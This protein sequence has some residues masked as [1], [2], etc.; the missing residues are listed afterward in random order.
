MATI[1][2]AEFAAFTIVIDERGHPATRPASFG[3]GCEDLRLALKL[4]DAIFQ[5]EHVIAAR[6]VHGQAS[7]QSLKLCQKRLSMVAHSLF[8]HCGHSAASIMRAS[9]DGFS[10]AEKWPV[11]FSVTICAAGISD[12]VRS[13]SFGRDQSLS[14]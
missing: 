13:R 10:T 6:I 14:P 7:A 9:S 12:R 5:P 4:C 1:A 11:F 8:D 3:P 2:F